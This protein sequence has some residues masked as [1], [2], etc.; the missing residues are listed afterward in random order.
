MEV[1]EAVFEGDGTWRLG[2]WVAVPP[3]EAADDPCGPGQAVGRVRVFQAFA[4]GLKLLVEGGKRVDFVSVEGNGRDLP[5]AI[6]RL[7]E[8]DGDDGRL[9]GDSD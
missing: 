1:F 2:R 9:G 5:T 8:L 3:A 4:L 7:Q 6:A